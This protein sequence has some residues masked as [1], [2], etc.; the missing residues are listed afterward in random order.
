[1][2]QLSLVKSSPE[3]DSQKTYI[4]NLQAGDKLNN[5]TFCVK[6]VKKGTT[7]TGKEYIDLTLADKTGTVAAKIW[8]DNLADCDNCQAGDVVRLSG[9]V[10]EFRE[11]LQIT[12]TF[13]QKTTDFEA[14]NF[15]P[16]SPKDLDELWLLFESYI[17]QIKNKHLKQLI[18]TLLGEKDFTAKL[19]LAPAA[20]MLHHAY[21]G[22]YLEHITEMYEA[23]L[24]LTVAYP[25]LN[26]D[27]LFVGILIHD[28]GKLEELG[29]SA[30][31]YRTIPGAL[32]GH[33]CLGLISVT[34][35]MDSLEDFPPELKTKVQ[36]LIVSHHGRIEFGSPILPM[37]REAHALCHLDDLSTK[38]NMADKNIS[39]RQGDNQNFSEKIYAL[40]C[41]L[42]L[43]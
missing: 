24:P 7:S 22:G 6:E 31:I 34:R 36:H 37:T 2:N 3:P 40:D 21:L 25:D 43:K 41:K 30:T 5:D 10:G 14:E 11:K 26:K 13:L 18:N 28:I 12:V 39:S 35:A 20:E 17:K 38:L 8:E 19:K 15:V 33:L 4:A 16:K 23:A 29:V 32:V 9:K 42:Y 27:L 1:M